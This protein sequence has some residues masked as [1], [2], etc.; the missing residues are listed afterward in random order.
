VAVLVDT[1]VLARLTNTADALHN[2]AIRAV[3]EL[4]NRGEVLHITA[5]NLIE[6]RVV[7][8]RPTA[9]NGLGM[10]AAEADS[11]ATVFEAVFP[12]LAETPGIYSA[13]KALVSGLAIL[14]KQGHDARL[15]AVCHVYGIP[16]LLTFNHTHFARL[17]AFPPG[18]VVIDPAGV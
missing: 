14:G 15:V 4:H 9:V 16:R 11:Q 18:I 2:T 8:T 12:L 5:Q 7:A 3:V 6:F 10:T 17:S 13:W 1:S